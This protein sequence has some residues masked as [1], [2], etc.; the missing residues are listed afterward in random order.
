MQQTDPSPSSS[1]FFKKTSKL[2]QLLLET[3]PHTQQNAQVLST[4]FA[5][6]LEGKLLLTVSAPL[7]IM[8]G[9]SVPTP[10]TTDKK[11][12]HQQLI[13]HEVEYIAVSRALNEGI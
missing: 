2:L 4:T 12:Q 1:F 8:F 11:Q 13:Q 9:T 6:T 7:Q 3:K 10:T 5:A